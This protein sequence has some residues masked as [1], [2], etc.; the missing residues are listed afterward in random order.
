MYK[1]IIN[2]IK[3]ELEKTL[4][5]LERELGKIRTSRAS[6]SLVEDV[7]VQCFGQKFH[8]K[9]LATI[10][11]TAKNEILIQPWDKS[12]VE[13]IVT[14]LSRSSLKMNPVVESDFIRFS[15]PPLSAEYR[16][17]LLQIIAQKKEDARITVRRWRGEVWDEIQTLTQTGKIPEDD[18]YRGK[19]ELQDLVD[20][21]NKKIEE[22]VEKKKKE[23]MK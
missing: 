2:R 17:N 3:P 11:V 9:Q 21:Y 15:L 19:S 7:E 22:V 4:D 10:S 5:Y 14:A 16:E 1:D 8:L 23:I 18:K 6:P 20:E 12:Y 13:P